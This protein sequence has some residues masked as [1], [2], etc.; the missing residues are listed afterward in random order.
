MSS[1]P[2]EKRRGWHWSDYWLSGRAEVMT[3]NTPTGPVTFGAEALW[4]AYFNG[5]DDGARL[6]DLATGSGQVAGYAAAAATAAGKAFEVVGVDY[7]E[8]PP[9]GPDAGYALMGG[10]ALESLPFP[11]AHFDGAASQFGLEYADPRPALAE[12]ARVL[13]PGGRVLML[14][15]HADSAITR[16]TADQIAA[17]DRVL[18]TGGVIRQ[19]RRA[20]ATRLK[21][22]PPATRQ[23]AA[24]AFCEA[25][26]RAAARLDPRPAFEPVRYLV[27]YLRDL[28]ERLDSYDPASALARL[29]AFE[30]GNAAW[31]QRQLCQTRAALDAA[32]LDALV[33]RGT[34]AGLELAER[35]PQ[36]DAGGALIGWRVGFLRS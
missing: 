15:H 27:G 8:A 9:P 30:T 23:A 31:R 20:F 4:A 33:A 3:V 12:L 2:V 10:V 7:A 13:K 28:A 14:I 25:V 1:S 6:L 18:G 26:N 32:G 17:Y 5:F 34:R 35:S 24:E 16:Q 29:D 22:A 11:T 21:P 36:H 19:A